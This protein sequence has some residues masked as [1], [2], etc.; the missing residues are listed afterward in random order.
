MEKNK[1][2][3]EI[4]RVSYVEEQYAKMNYEEGMWP[5]RAVEAPTVSKGARAF[6]RTKEGQEFLKELKAELLRNIEKAYN[7]E[8]EKLPQYDDVYEIR[9]P[10]PIGRDWEWKYIL[11]MTPWY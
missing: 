6:L 9:N 10:N 1:Y 11:I 7:A 8:A 2:E 4:R 3:Q 5:L